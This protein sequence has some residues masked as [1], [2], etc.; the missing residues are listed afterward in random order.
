[1]VSVFV[2]MSRCRSVY[3][4]NSYCRSMQ[5][6]VCA[7]ISTGK[8][9]TTFI[10]VVYICRTLPPPC[11]CIFKAN[12]STSRRT[13]AAAIAYMY[14]SYF[15]ISSNIIAMQRSSMSVARRRMKLDMYMNCVKVPPRF[16]V[17]AKQHAEQM[18]NDVAI[19]CD[20]GIDHCV[21]Q[22]PRERR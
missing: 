19:V 15:S 10:L 21:P 11:I 9:Q 14:P 22:L 13:Q 16:A 3:Y 6:K 8:G 2:S 5:V 12:T 20:G 17:M 1:M 4:S 18:I 7:Q